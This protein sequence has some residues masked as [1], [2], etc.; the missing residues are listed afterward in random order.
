M[1][2][3]ANIVATLYLVSV[4]SHAAIAQ[5]APPP[6]LGDETK[7][8]ETKSEEIIGAA[9]ENKT[10]TAADSTSSTESENPSKS[11]TPSTQKERSLADSL[12]GNATIKETRRES[13]QLYRIELEHSTGSKQII[14]ENDSDGQLSS[15]DNGL[16]DTPNLTKWQLLSW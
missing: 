16:D 3:L 5:T 12:L 4:A 15:D 7:G 9:V 6:S 13:G 14:E 10:R 2:K 1:H 11:S 8:E